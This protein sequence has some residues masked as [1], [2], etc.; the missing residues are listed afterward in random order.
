MDYKT[1]DSMRRL[2]CESCKGY[3]D[4]CGI[5]PV[6]RWTCPY[7]GGYLVNNHRIVPWWHGRSIPGWLNIKWKNRI[8]GIVLIPKFYLEVHIW[9]AGEKGQDISMG[10]AI[11]YF[12]NRA[13]KT[14]KSEIEVIGNEEWERHMDPDSY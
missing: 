5:N 3:F 2:Q 4:F 9:L 10:D 11:E 1:C 7:C 14:W 6:S 13:K 12:R 8:G